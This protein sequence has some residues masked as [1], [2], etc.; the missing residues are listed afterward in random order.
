MQTCLIV[1]N[2]EFFCHRILEN[3]ATPGRFS[4]DQKNV[5]LFP[6]NYLN[7]LHVLYFLVKE[8]AKLPHITKYVVK[9][10]PVE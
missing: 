9:L 10:T 1:Y 8:T 4:N 7:Q 3:D 6:I 5:Y 2:M